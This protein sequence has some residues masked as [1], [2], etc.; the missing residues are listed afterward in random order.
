MR[1][2]KYEVRRLRL[3]EIRDRE[4]GGNTSELARRLDRNPTYVLRMLYPAGKAGKKRIADDMIEVIDSVF[5][6]PHG[7]LDGKDITNTTEWPFKSVT[8][9]RFHKLS[10]A[11]QASIESTVLSMVTAFLGAE[12]V[13]RRT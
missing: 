11:Q 1:M 5:N 9:A 6:L 10:Q 12:S 3:I 8:P 4:C 7:W 13:R 2:D